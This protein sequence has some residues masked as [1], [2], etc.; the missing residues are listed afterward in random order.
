MRRPDDVG[1]SIAVL[2]GHEQIVELLLNAGGNIQESKDSALDAVTI[3]GHV[4]VVLV[5][6]LLLKAGAVVENDCAPGLAARNC[7]VHVVPQRCRSI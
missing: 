5:V 4:G 3:N 1:L 2:Q 7:H 6:R